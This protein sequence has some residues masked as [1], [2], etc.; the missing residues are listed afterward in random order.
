[1]RTEDIL[2]GLD[3]A[4]RQAV[5]T[6]K[7]AVVV[8]GA[9]SG[10]TRVLTRRFLYLVIEK[11]VKPSRIMALTFTRKA[12][13]E[14][15]QRI[16]EGI[17]ES[18]EENLIRDFEKAVISTIDSFCASVV[19]PYSSRYGFAPDFSICNGE[20]L[21]GLSALAR[22]F[23]LRSLQDEQ[24]KNSLSLLCKDWEPDR[25]V[26]DVLMDYAANYA[27]ITGYPVSGRWQYSDRFTKLLEDKIEEIE[28][29]VRNL[30]S[31]CRTVLDIVGNKKNKTTEKLDK[32]LEKESELISLF[33]N[34]PKSLPE[35]KRL[36][37]SFVLDRTAKDSINPNDCKKELINLSD[38]IMH[39]YDNLEDNLVLNDFI[40][41]WHDEVIA[42]KRRHNLLTFSDV[43]S[44]AV[45]LIKKDKGIRAFYKE[46]FDYILVDEFQDN[47]ELQKEFLFFLA[48]KK[49]IFSE[50]VP[51]INSLERGKLFIVGDEKQS[52]YLFR[53]ADV[54]VFNSL[55]DDAVKPD[56]PDM[57]FIR[58]A[59][60]YRS[61]P[62]LVDFFN[63]ISHELFNNSDAGGIR[64]DPAEKRMDKTILEPSVFVGIQK[65]SADVVKNPFY[66]KDDIEAAWV[67]AKLKGLVENSSLMVRD[68]RSGELR[69]LA[70]G[71]IAVL[72]RSTTAQL[73]YE[74]AM[75]REGIPYVAGVSRN[76]FLEAAVND[77]VSWLFIIVYPDDWLSFYAVLRGPLCALSDK[78]IT[79]VIK[80][81]KERRFPVCFS[82][83]DSELDMLGL[84][85]PDAYKRGR[86]IYRELS[87]MADRMSPAE[88]IRY[89][90]YDAGYRFML[91]KRIDF[92]PFLKVY[93]ELLFLC[94][95]YEGK[96]L[97]SFIDY[98]F[99]ML[100]RF[101]KQELYDVPVDAE[102]S[103]KIMTIHASKGLE[104][105]FVALV[106]VGKSGR[107]ESEKSFPYAFIDDSYPV[108]SF[109]KS[110]PVLKDYL[111]KKKK[112]EEYELRRLLY[113]ALTRAESH[114]LIAGSIS[115]RNSDNSFLP[116]LFSDA[117]EMEL[118]ASNHVRIIKEEIKQDSV[119]FK[120]PNTR[121]LSELKHVYKECRP[122]LGPYIKKSLSV[123]VI[124]DAYEKT[125]K[126]I[127]KTFSSGYDLHDSTVYGNLVHFLIEKSAFI[128]DKER[129]KKYVLLNPDAIGALSYDEVDAFFDK[130]YDAV[131]GLSSRF[132]LSS[133]MHE[134]DVEIKYR[135][136]YIHGKLDAVKIEN[137]SVVIYEWKTGGFP[138]EYRMQVFLY[139]RMA[140]FLWK[141]NNISVRLVFTGKGEPAVYEFFKEDDWKEEETFLESFLSS[142]DTF[143]A[144][145]TSAYVTDA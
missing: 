133:L 93:D 65:K 76:M 126:N 33:D 102:S 96:S 132:E 22:T 17:R 43:F 84:D 143:I 134:Y 7:N 39:M 5:I 36:L 79:K 15:R 27:C 81:E 10:K 55:R 34:V 44:A 139:I 14:M 26:E 95:S 57:E 123:S 141:K 100:G 2:R 129:L 99:D 87:Y 50:S 92:H 66:S 60:N 12:A 13:S 8:A 127:I 94:R 6:D 1:M 91:L 41:M 62:A 45:E 89:L 86:T 4:Q 71:D 3:S 142:V 20:E 130:A 46:R 21:E 85:S 135:D 136:Y 67:A 68:K 52:I 56:Y 116:L 109:S 121:L 63:E 47:N 97:A 64:F 9:G 112:L 72:M 24:F 106:S 88:L 49:G 145:G 70:Y 32:V 28:T 122:E 11:N 29:G 90:W 117:E 35:I 23:F 144:D 61:E 37:E 115:E 83:S 108:F 110:N 119:W 120:K 101:E 18:G 80:K 107:K 105:P 114:L 53:G 125:K 77:L 104:F 138:E 124:A 128:K 140:D 69:P 137:N 58:L 118:K 113:V 30:F 131:V 111:D 51:D 74:K 40:K 103:V 48:E 59:H 38:D 82:L 54:S 31:S 25:I 98:L 73:S 75:R 78:D 16:A 19:R 42:F